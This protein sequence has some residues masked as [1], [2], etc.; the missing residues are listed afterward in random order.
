VAEGIGQLWATLLLL[1]RPEDRVI[2]VQIV[3]CLARGIEGE[4]GNIA[5]LNTLD[6]KYAKFSIEGVTVEPDRVKV[7]AL[8][9][10]FKEPGT[11][12]TDR[13]KRI[14]QLVR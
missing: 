4:Q 7:R 1:P 12:P 6:K 13:P 11:N 14:V 3:D 9:K 2:S 10:G 5:W 8:F